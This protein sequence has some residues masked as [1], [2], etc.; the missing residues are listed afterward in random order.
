MGDYQFNVNEF[1][2][3]HILEMITEVRACRPEIIQRQAQI[4]KR[5]RRLA[6][7]GKLTILAADHPGRGATSL[8]DDPW[9][10]ANRREYLA[11]ILR[12]LTQS[13]FD[14]F[15]STPDM[16]EDLLILD[17]LVQQAAGPSFLDDKVLIGC[18]QRGGVAGVA[19]EI[20]DRFSAYTPDSLARLRLDGGKMM[21]RFAFD[22]ERTLH[23][24]YY[25]AQA[26]GGLNAHRLYSFV[27]PLNMVRNGNGWAVKNETDALVKL[28]GVA[29]ALGD[30][31]QYL[32]LKIPYCDDFAR[33]AAATTLP[34]LLLG[35]PSNEDPRETFYDFA[36]AID[37]NAN[38]RGAMVGRNVTYPGAE[39]PAGVA[40]AVHAIVHHGITADEAL[41]TT[42]RL[43]DKGLDALT[44]YL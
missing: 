17:Y 30:S 6:P 14:G 28:V 39:D 36:Q 15:M 27:E 11:R 43:R 18:M 41:S 7:R 2:P 26:I 34:L 40:Q 19:G 32:W 37:T 12:V 10:M 38:V 25:C 29:S 21:F 13:N 24:I 33:V 4:R 31:S 22:D 35:G 1:F 42:V 44:R 16:V 23:T 9:R 3:E 8:G 20:D 5:R